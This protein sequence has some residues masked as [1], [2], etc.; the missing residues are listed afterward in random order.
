MGNV[1]QLDLSKTTGRVPP[2]RVL[3]AALAA[4]LE[5][6]AVVGVAGDGKLYIAFSDG[7]VLQILGSLDIAKFMIMQAIEDEA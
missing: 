7:D 5:D 4:N 6:V 3:T 2:E 1:V